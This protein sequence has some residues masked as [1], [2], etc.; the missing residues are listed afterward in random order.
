MG[1]G[2]AQCVVAVAIA[3][4]AIVELGR[5]TSGRLHCGRRGGHLETTSI[6]PN[7]AA[8]INQ[9]SFSKADC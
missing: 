3:G 8:L 4:F 7:M 2:V 6:W 1:D 9:Q 5:V